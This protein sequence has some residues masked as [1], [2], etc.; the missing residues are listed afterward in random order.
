MDLPK[1]VKAR[2][3]SLK[4]CLPKGMPIMVRHSR[5][6]KSKWVRAIQIPPHKS[7][8][9]FIIVDRQPVLEDVSVIFTPKGARPT[10]ANLKHWRPNGIPTMVRHKINPPIRYSKKIIIPPKIIHNMLPIMF[11]V[12]FIVRSELIRFVTDYEQYFLFYVCWYLFL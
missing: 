2:F 4:C 9:M 5:M 3:I 1:G 6:P 8:I 12:F 7:H 11:I 10:K